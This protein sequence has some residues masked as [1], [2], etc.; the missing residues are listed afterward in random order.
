MPKSWNCCRRIRSE[1]EYF[2][3]S[4]DQVHFP[5]ERLDRYPVFQLEIVADSDLGNVQCGE[6]AVVKA[7]SPSE[8]VMLAVESHARNNDQVYFAFRYGH[9]IFGRFRNTESAMQEACWKRSVSSSRSIILAERSS[10][11]VFVYDL[12]KEAIS[13]RSVCLALCNSIG[14]IVFVLRCRE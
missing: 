2:F 4:Y 3:F 11:V 14:C 13:S 5:V 12:F 1:S 9:A 7:F 6:Q 8:A 10:N